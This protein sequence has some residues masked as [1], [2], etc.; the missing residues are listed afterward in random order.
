MNKNLVIAMILI[1]IIVVFGII[2]LLP[3]EKAKQETTIFPKPEIKTKK[4]SVAQ[5]QTQQ[6]KA[7]KPSF[8][9]IF[10]ESFIEPNKQTFKE[11][12]V[13]FKNIIKPDL[14]KQKISQEMNGQAEKSTAIERE[15]FN[16][17]YPDY[18]I[19]GLMETQNFLLEN[20]FLAE[21]YKKIE[22]F[23]S[24]E[25]IFSFVNTIID[26]FE[27]QGI[28]SSEEAKQF[29]KG[30]NEI[31]RNLM[32]EEKLV[33]QNKLIKSDFYK[34]AS[35][36]RIYNLKQLIS[37]K[38]LKIFSEL[39]NLAIP[40]IYASP[41][42]YREGPVGPDGSNVWAPCCNC[43]FNCDDDGCWFVEDCGDHC[44][45]DLGCLNLYAG[46]DKPAIWDES[47]GICGVGG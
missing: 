3:G 6:I 4:I 23:N 24:E 18:F 25:E 43:G 32:T 39:K 47:S 2:L 14:K 16:Q 44:D 27:K 31:W 7:E 8:S 22:S 28:Y 35:A 1:A 17:L 5:N 42:C 33:L 37:Q 20:G 36:N 19:N 34:H 15:I 26:V 11:I 38:I 12:G 21:D 45:I 46:D 9:S 40:R 41:D 30:A 10:Q 29:R 13:S